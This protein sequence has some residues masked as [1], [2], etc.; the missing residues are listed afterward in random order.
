[1]GKL[2]L[3][4]AFQSASGALGEM[5]VSEV[6][7]AP[8]ARRRPRYKRPTAPSQA[9][10]AQRFA[11]ACEAWNALTPNQAQQ[12]RDY[13][14]SVWRSN[15]MTG[16]RYRG[17]A[18]TEFVALATTFLQATPNGSIPLSPPSDSYIADRV[19]INVSAIEEGARWTASAAN[20][21]DT[22]TELMVQKLPSPRRKP[23][24]QY[25][26]AAFVQ[27]TAGALSHDLPLDPGTY[28]LAYRFIRLSTGQPTLRL[29]AGLITVEE[30]TAPLKQS[31]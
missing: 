30:A 19:T 8:I 21:P 5:I 14:E 26:A 24:K 28:S 10:A 1:M 31:A 17:N 25:T 6:R 18:M 3:S 23:T 20:E 27:F 11:Q 16:T 7:G 13:A 29:I 15:A 12:W 4:A 9:A 22:V 2:K